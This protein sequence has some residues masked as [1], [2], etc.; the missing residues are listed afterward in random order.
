MADDA[1]LLV[2]LAPKGLCAELSWELHGTSFGVCDMK[3]ASIVLLPSG[4]VFSKSSY[5]VDLTVVEEIIC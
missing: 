4:K 2:E 3:E 5:F 1:S